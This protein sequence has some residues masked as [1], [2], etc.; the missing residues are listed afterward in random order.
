M[1]TVDRAFLRAF[2]ENSSRAEQGAPTLT[3]SPLTQ[4]AVSAKPQAAPPRSPH[5]AARSAT[6]AAANSTPP[7]TANATM[8]RPLSSFVA[9][10]ATVDARFRPALEVDAFAWPAIVEDLVSTYSDRWQEAVVTMVEADAAGCSLVG[11]AGLGSGVGATTTALALARLLVAAGKTIALV[12]AD[13]RMAQL[14]SYLGLAVQIG[15]EDVLAGR[16]PLAEAMIHSLGDRMALLPLVRGGI[17]ASEKLDAI[18]SSITAGVLRYHYDIVLFDLGDVCDQVQ[19]PIAR[20]TARQCRLDA[21][22]LVAGPDQR[23]RAAARTL[24]E[25]APELAA[26]C[27]GMIE[28]EE[29]RSAIGD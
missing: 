12:D 5:F 21:T 15:W 20:R 13:F 18:H 28:V 27:R 10:P 1:S 22:L 11:V 19:S 2:E 29:A 24:V 14:A 7:S 3:S 4:E 17:P 16:T 26:I 25:T 6:T 9:P 23:S 8:R